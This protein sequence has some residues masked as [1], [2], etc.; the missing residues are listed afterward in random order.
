M[1][2]NKEQERIESSFL[3]KGFVLNLG[4]SNSRYVT[5]Q[6]ND[7]N[8]YVSSSEQ[9]AWEPK[10]AKSVLAKKLFPQSERSLT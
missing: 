9:L 3:N 2:I 4:L 10:S 8:V 1:L 7:F 5:L 6:N